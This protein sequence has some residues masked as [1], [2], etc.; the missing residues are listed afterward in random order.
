M[1]DKIIVNQVIYCIV[2][3]LSCFHNAI[4]FL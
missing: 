4:T 1:I 2:Q 3:C